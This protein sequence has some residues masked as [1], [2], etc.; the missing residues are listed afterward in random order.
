VQTDELIRDLASHAAPVRRLACWSRRTALWTA[1]ALVSV[2]T[3]VLVLGARRDLL[4]VLT[5]PGFAVEELLLLTTAVTAAAG[6]LIVAVPGAERSALVRWLPVMAG[7]AALAWAGA[8]LAVAAA[9][10]GA[11]GRFVPAWHCVGRTVAAGLVP[12]I[13]LLIMV[14]SAAPLRA[15]WAGLLA[16]L[17]TSAIGV[18]A[19]NM[20][21]FNDRP[22]HVL[23]WHVL[24]MSVIA[25]LGAALGVWLL[26][27]TRGLKGGRLE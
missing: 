20:I 16:L 1:L 21:C 10:D 17:A 24:P 8:V 18:L 13:A 3:V 5:S 26:R 4:E 7:V 11:T 14:R 22:L 12:G 6:A 19:T 9:T 25:A 23:I 15:A 2:A 27:W